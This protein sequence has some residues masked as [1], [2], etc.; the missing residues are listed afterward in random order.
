MPLTMPRP[1]V[2][3]TTVDAGR[4]RAEMP[5]VVRTYEEF[6]ISSARLVGL[7]RETSSSRIRPDPTDK[8]FRSCLGA[9][10]RTSVEALHG[11]MKF[12][13]IVRPSLNSNSWLTSLATIAILLLLDEA[14]GRALRERSY[15]GRR[16]C[17]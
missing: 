12:P 14:S 15:R 5:S 3:A 16:F 10:K 9:R 4:R 7:V 6:A 8:T 17:S 2:N 13:G 11:L 1:R